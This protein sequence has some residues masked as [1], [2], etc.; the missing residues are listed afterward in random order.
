MLTNGEGRPDITAT[1]T[2]TLIT[3]DSSG[4]NSLSIDVEGS[5]AVYAQV[6]T[7][8]DDFDTAYAAGKTIKVRQNIP[9]GFYGDAKVNI[10]NVV[11]RT[12]SSTS[13]VNFSAF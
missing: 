5:N 13:V 6:N 2:S 7:T 3:F 9:F 12:A 4:A 11:Y 8:T 10:K 1:T